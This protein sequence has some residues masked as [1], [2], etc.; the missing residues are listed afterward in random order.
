MLRPYQSLAIT[1]LYNWFNANSIGNPCLVLPTGSGKS[2]IIAALCKD[3]IL[4]YPNTRILMLCHVKELIEQNAEKMRLHWLDAPLGI[5]SASIGSK[6]LN[7]IT[8]GGIQSLR[9]KA[10]QIGHIDLVIIDEA[11]LVSHKDEGGYRNLLNELKTINPYFRVIGLTASPYRLGHGL[12]TDKPA[13]FDDLIEPTSIEELVAKGYLA[14]LRS[15]LTKAQLEVDGV[16]KRGGEFIESELQK[17]VNTKDKNKAIVNEVIRL[18]GDRKSWLFFCAGI[19]HAQE[20][21]KT[22]NDCGIHA[23]S[24]TGNTPKAEREKLFKEFKAGKITALTGANIFTTGFDAPNIDL[25]A[26]LRPTMSPGLYV[27]MAGRGMRLKDH[28]DH[29]L[30]LDF[31]GAVA[32][33]GPITNITP[34]TKSGSG[35]GESPVKVCDH[36]AELCHV[37]A[38]ECPACGELFPEPKEKKFKLRN[39]DIMGLSGTQMEITAWEWKEHI[40]RASGKRMLRVDY[41]GALSDPP[42]SEYLTITYE[43]WAGNKAIRLLGDIAEK[44][45]AIIVNDFFAIIDAMN[46]SKPPKIIEYKKNGKYNQVVKRSW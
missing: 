6:E 21:A 25:I 1:Q 34:P 41:Y 46:N 16:H 20:I 29:C 17:K 32:T 2:H 43:G 4:N 10:T 5:Y 37:S 11:H 27:Q 12:I 30:V 23:H 7:Q 44:S 15:K 36:C 13:I 31:A 33:H 14:T 38:K 40:S 19:D 3:A 45:G 28:T 42:I 8:F 9:K 35:N 24:V 18:A 22:L 26:L 39:D